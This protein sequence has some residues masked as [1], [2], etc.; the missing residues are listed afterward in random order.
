MGHSLKCSLGMVNYLT[1]YVCEALYVQ[2]DVIHVQG[3]GLCDRQT[4][5]RNNLCNRKESHFRGS[6]RV[7]AL[8]IV[9]CWRWIHVNFRW[10]ISVVWFICSTGTLD[11]RQY[12]ASCLSHFQ[13]LCGYDVSSVWLSIF[14]TLESTD[15]IVMVSVSSWHLM[16]KRDL[17]SSINIQIR[18]DFTVSDRAAYTPQYLFKYQ[19]HCVH[20]CTEKPNSSR[21][22]CQILRPVHLVFGQ[23]F[24]DINAF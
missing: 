18:C 10:S 9:F 16:M 13:G 6:S 1:E 2:C 19:T 12:C 21:V 23:I 15:I 24:S 4:I 11:T 14:K 3:K 22:F 7:T 8:Q 20:N 17:K 5:L